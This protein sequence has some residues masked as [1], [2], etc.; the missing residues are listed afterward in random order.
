MLEEGIDRAT[1]K[2]ELKEKYNISLSGEVYELPCHLQPVF[3]NLG[4]KEGDFPVAEDICKRHICLPIFATMTEEQAKYV[5]ES[6]E[7]VIS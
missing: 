1:L 6:L 3:K 7:E 4:Y 2:K 5:I